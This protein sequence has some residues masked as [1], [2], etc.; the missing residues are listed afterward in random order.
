MGG[1]TPQMQDFFKM[2]KML[3]LLWNI[4]NFIYWHWSKL[5]VECNDALHSS[6]SLSHSSR[7]VREL[8]GSPLPRLPLLW[9]VKKANSLSLGLKDAPWWGFQSRSQNWIWII[10]DHILSEKP[11][12]LS[13]ITIF[14][15]FDGFRLKHG[16]NIIQIQFGDQIWNP[17]IMAHLLD[18]KTK[19]ISKIVKKTKKLKHPTVHGM[20]D[21]G[22]I[23]IW[24]IQWNI[25]TGNS[26]SIRHFS[27]FRAKLLRVCRPFSW[28]KPSCG[29]TWPGH[30]RG[31]L[32]AGTG[33]RGTGY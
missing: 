16:S 28:K 18:P 27:Q 12:I 3:K 19:G 5:F 1:V 11:S 8:R 15:V 29:A 23:R 31:N 9:E 22:G 26:R 10:F 6:R 7:D 30:I 21:L 25:P 2:S 32:A 33:H 20:H 13:R 24:T 14:T 4:A 17:L